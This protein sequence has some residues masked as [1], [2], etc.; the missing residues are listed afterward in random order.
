MHWVHHL[1]DCDARR[2][3][4]GVRQVDDGG[5]H[6]RLYW[7]HCSADVHGRLYWA[8]RI[9]DDDTPGRGGGAPHSSDNGAH[10]RGGDARRA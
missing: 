8:H 9:A 6:G 10:Q 5:A 3:R 4:Y 2:G 7:A 1:A